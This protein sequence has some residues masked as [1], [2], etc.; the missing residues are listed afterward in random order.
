MRLF[1][2]GWRD[3]AGASA[4][5]YGLIVFAIAAVISVVVFAFGGAVHGLFDTS[6]KTISSQTQTGSCPP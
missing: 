1:R 6:C 4:V 2:A 5:E 3:E